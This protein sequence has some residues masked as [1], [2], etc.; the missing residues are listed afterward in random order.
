MHLQPVCKM[1][2]LS[3]INIV[4]GTDELLKVLDLL[5]PKDLLTTAALVCSRWWVWFSRTGFRAE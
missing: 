5:S 1:G 3:A 4:L 2:D